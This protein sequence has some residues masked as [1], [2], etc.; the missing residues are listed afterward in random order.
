MKNGLNIFLTE[1]TR[2][3]RIEP[4]TTTIEDDVKNRK[5]QSEPLDYRSMVQIL[6]EE[7][8]PSPS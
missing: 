6:K 7:T 1:S 3:A 2:Q 5:R 4:G 8:P